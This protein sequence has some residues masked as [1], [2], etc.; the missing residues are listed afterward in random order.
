MKNIFQ[1]ELK[2]LFRDKKTIFFIFILP[3]LLMPVLSGGLTFFTKS[4]L[5]SISE[6]K[7]TVLMQNDPFVKKLEG[8]FTVRQIT[9]VYVD[10]IPVNVDSLKKQL[11]THVAVIGV[12]YPDS[13]STPLLTVK[14][15]TAK[16][17]QSIHADRVIDL[18]KL[19]KRK[20]INLKY[21]EIGISDYWKAT[22]ITS[23]NNADRIK[24]D[25]RDYAKMLPNSLIF[26]L[27]FGVFS[28]ASYV[29]LGEK[30]N[31]T[32]ETLLSTGVKRSTIIKGKFSLVIC[33]GVI[34]SFLDFI[35]FYLYG[36]FASFANYT[37]HF[38][39]MQ[40]ISF[41]SLSVV[42]AFFFASV[43]IN[44]NCRMKSTSSASMVMMP[45]NILV[46]LLM[47]AGT[48]DGV[49]IER[50]LL[51][52]P[53]I[54][55]AGIL[56]AVV[57]NDYAFSS[58]LIIILTTAVYS[59]V[60]ISG[61]AKILSRE[62]ILERD[63][64]DIDLMTAND[65][66]GFALI[67]FMVFAMFYLQLGGYLQGKNLAWGLAISLVV[68]IGGGSV[69]ILKLGKEKLLPAFRFK[70]FH[71]GYLLMAL[72][73]GL[74]ARFPIS[75]LKEGIDFLFPMPELG[76]NTV[77]LLEKAMAGISF[78]VMLLV[79]AILPGIFEELLFRGAFLKLVERGRG[80]WKT[81]LIVGALFGA[82]HL[83]IFRFLET[84]L[85]GV[86]LT[87]ITIASGSI[88]PAMI[89]H[90][91]NNG[92]SFILMDYAKDAKFS[93]MLEQWSELYH[94]DAIIATLTILVL[95]I[96]M[97]IPCWKQRNKQN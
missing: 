57:M 13:L 32:L 54:N 17:K 59:W 24:T 71:P 70:G 35:S 77:A 41:V 11:T 58:V 52:I 33:A 21:Q 53:I 75:Y 76:G 94:L 22:E 82:M 88:F 44:I 25:S 28:L 64:E 34:I 15:I 49:T 7:V 36:K 73:L 19:L 78:P 74:F 51:L 27:L 72:F 30:D 96:W 63:T 55:F 16:D 5:K 62:D 47:I 80:I 89:F 90:I 37:V 6:E 61:A 48:F 56:K 20:M 83:D 4:R 9:P 2:Q 38:D 87:Y 46:I 84:G 66:L 12:A 69:V 8:A 29:I 14:Y 3:M 95:A 18:L 31:K 91:V 50:G 43:A 93:T 79:V 81:S 1:F 67:S 39:L 26:I 85:L 60:L 10:S 23:I 42:M 92:S 97:G 65:K 68:I 40:I 86:L 45:L